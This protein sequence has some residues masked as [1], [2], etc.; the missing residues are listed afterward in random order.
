MSVV[1]LIFQSC[2]FDVGSWAHLASEIDIRPKE[3]GA[4]DMRFFQTSSVFDVISFGGEY[5]TYNGEWEIN[6]L[7]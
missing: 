2:A 3:D 5:V 6:S 4:A 7:R 1:F